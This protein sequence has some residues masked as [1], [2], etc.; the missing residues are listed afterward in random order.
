MGNGKKA[1]PEPI[2]HSE[3]REPGAEVLVPAGKSGGLEQCSLAD[4]PT[5]SWLAL[6]PFLHRP[7]DT[8]P[9]GTCACDQQDLC[10]SKEGALTPARL[11][12][13]FF[14]YWHQTL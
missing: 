10:H 13:C 11:H 8:H 9:P 2:P 3:H 1:G 14:I 5:A 4:S 6:T 7:Q 12:V